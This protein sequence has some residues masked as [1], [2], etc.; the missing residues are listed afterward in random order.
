MA[1][2]EKALALEKV[3]DEI[4]ELILTELGSNPY[5][6][7]EQAKKIVA[8]RIFHQFPAIERK[9][10]NLTMLLYNRRMTNIKELDKKTEEANCILDEITSKL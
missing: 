5:K 2:N 4:I 1:N 6:E 9:L 10:G 7:L 3:L 8:Q